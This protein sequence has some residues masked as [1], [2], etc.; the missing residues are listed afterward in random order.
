MADNGGPPST[1]PRRGELA[2]RLRA[3]FGFRSFRP[4]QERAVRAAM[5][6][7]DTLVVMPTGSGKS[8]CFQLPAL[9]LPG[10]T[11]VVSPLIALM[12]DQTEALRERG[13]EA[14]AVNSTLSDADRAEAE[15]RIRDGFH[16]FIY[17]TPEQLAAPEFRALLKAAAIDLFVVDE[18]HCVSQWGHDFRPE[19]LSL[20]SV[21]Q[22]LGQ[23]T[24][25]ALTATATADVVEDVLRGLGI[26]DAEVVHTGFFRPNLHLSARGASDDDEKIGHLIEFLRGEV[27]GSGIIYSAT[28]KG[29]GEI[30]E[31]LAEAGL[32]VTTYHG[33][34]RRSERDANQDNFMGGETPIMVATNAFGMGI[35]KPDVRFVV[36][37][38]PP[39]NIESFYQEFGRAGRDGEPARCL[40]L[41]HQAD[42][43]LQNFFQ[44]GRHPSGEDL[45]NAH[46]ALKRFGEEPPTFDQL[47]ESS[48]LPRT[49]LKAALNLF[50]GRQ[51]VKE[52]L[53]GRLLLLRDDMDRDNLTRL[54]RSYEEKD[55]RDRMN[56]QRLIDY[57]TTRSC[58]WAVILDY[59]GD[60]VPA[61]A[62][63]LCD[64]CRPGQIPTASVA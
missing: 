8:L 15:A 51:I 58:R 64:N 21:I 44:G 32:D 25:L 2:R 18:A 27:G 63:G 52:D 29:V 62:C 19:Y 3:Q 60:D 12:K 17:T 33:R 10:A 57:A 28:V 7:L 4:G 45:V 49:K 42:W 22:D 9:E 59:F 11:V 54:A 50:R 20:G 55:E 61:D 6:G 36:H 56:L 34:M 24:V 26:P 43:K 38:N 53:T 16:G 37:F 1:T 46:H 30:A 39:G 23:P 48:P 35:D 14:I 31:R 5:D 41:H 40:L 47:L 13:F